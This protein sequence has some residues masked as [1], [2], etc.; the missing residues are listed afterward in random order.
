MYFELTK[1]I[2]EGKKG[3]ATE[4]C[5]QTT[6]TAEQ[7]FKNVK[8]YQLLEQEYQGTSWDEDWEI[9]NPYPRTLSMESKRKNGSQ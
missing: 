4:T 7:P 3:Q 9:Q 6:R 8:Q 2:Q 5:L 1:K